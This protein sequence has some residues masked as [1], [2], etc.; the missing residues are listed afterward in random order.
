MSVPKKVAALAAELR[1]AIEQHNYAYH[2]LDAPIVPDVEY[3]RLMRELVALEKQHPELVSADSPT[4]RVGANPN[5][6]FG[7]VRHAVA[8]GSSWSSSK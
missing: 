4:Q 2:V 5:T 8:F 7:E 6:E 1:A 3:D